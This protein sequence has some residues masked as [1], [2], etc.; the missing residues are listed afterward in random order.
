[1]T[2]RIT[3][4]QTERHPAPTGFEKSLGGENFFG[5]CRI[6]SPLPGNNRVAGFDPFGA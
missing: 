2:G 3:A 6:F 1:M 5:D 4:P